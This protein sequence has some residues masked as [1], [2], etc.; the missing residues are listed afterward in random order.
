MTVNDRTIKFEMWDT[1]GQENKC[2][3]TKKMAMFADLQLV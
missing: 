2:R 3:F 1:A